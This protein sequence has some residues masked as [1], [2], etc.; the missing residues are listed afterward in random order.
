MLSWYAT[1]LDG[2]HYILIKT[3]YSR[4]LLRHLSVGMNVCGVSTLVYPQR[5]VVILVILVLWGKGGW[6]KDSASRLPSNIGQKTY[7]KYMDMQES[8]CFAQ[9]PMLSE[10]CVLIPLVLAFHLVLEKFL[11]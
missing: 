6:E 2:L 5:L 3:F 1:R 7:R 10:R 9:F 11:K 4:S 8:Q